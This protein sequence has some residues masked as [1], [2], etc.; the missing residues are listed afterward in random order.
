MNR[1]ELLKVTAAAGTLPWLASACTSEDSR[2]FASQYLTGNFG[3]VEAEVTATGLTVTGQIPEQLVGRYLRNGPNPI[4]DVDPLKHHWFI[5]DGM[6]HGVRLD[7]GQ[8][9][10]YRNRWVRSTHVTNALGEAAEG[11]L[12]DFGPNTHVI[13][14]AD[15]TWALVEGGAPPVELDD[16]LETIGVNT[17]AGTLPG[18]FTAHPKL[19]PD[20]G[21]LHAMC[22]WWP[23]QRGYV[24]YVRIGRDGQV[25]KSVDIPIDGM[26]MIH[27]MSITK[28]FIVIYDLPVTVKL[29]MLVTRG[30]FPFAWDDDHG[31]RVGLLPR[32]GTAEDVI[33]IE[34]SP[35]YVY[36]PMNAYDDAEG[37]VV[38]DVCRYERMFD[39]DI[40]GPFGDNVPTLDRWTLNPAT[41]RASETRIDERGQEFPR[42]HP[43]RLGKPYRYGYTAGVEGLDFSNIYKHDLQTGETESIAMGDGRHTG[44]PYF[45]P[46]EGSTAEDDGILMSYVYDTT[47]NASELVIWD[48]QDLSAP[49]LAR[50]HLPA[51]VPY[52]FHGSWV[53]DE[54]VG[55]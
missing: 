47:K 32:D 54:G 34:V 11:V 21:E 5:G 46:R 9:V 48:A 14:F 25:N 39:K 18:G 4:E 19:D 37:N 1:R 22:Y 49:A 45:I 7:G 36:H 13:G 20:T 27:D 2:A 38:I 17:F 16:E 10:W 3:P 28:R 52:G 42:C 31:A 55:V 51:R 30:G 6:V 40:Y 44:E 12:P 29:S 26:P 33:W 50:V 15:S 35:G 23:N 24:Q 53:P 43:G 41:R 8:A